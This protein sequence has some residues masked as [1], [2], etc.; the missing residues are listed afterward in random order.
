MGQLGSLHGRGKR[1]V[2]N[3]LAWRVIHWLTPPTAERLGPGVLTFALLGVES[4]A[5]AGPI[6]CIAMAANI[7]NPRMFH[8]PVF[9][10]GGTSG[11]CQGGAG[12]LHHV[13]TFIPSNPTAP[14]MA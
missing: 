14:H 10:S 6:M 9:P 3:D 7:L 4:V 12:L 8:G 5:P 1:S 2:P 13:S 11:V